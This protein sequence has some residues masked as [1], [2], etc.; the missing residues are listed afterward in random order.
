[1]DKIPVVNYNINDYPEFYLKHINY[2]RTKIYR[3]A[4]PL[5]STIIT[6]LQISRDAAP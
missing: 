1:M 5:D 2:L 6:F 4:A 3:C